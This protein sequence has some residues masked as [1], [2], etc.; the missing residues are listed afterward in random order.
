MKKILAV[1]ILAAALSLGL[2]S[3][4]A[5]RH[6]LAPVAGVA[7]FGDSMTENAT[8]YLR[9]HRPK[10]Y[11]DGVW[12]RPVTDL[13]GRVRYYLRTHALPPRVAIIALGTNERA[14]WSRWQYRRVNHLFPKRTRV[15]YVNTYRPGRAS[16]GARYS[17]WMA[18]IERIRKRTTIAD[19]R[20][21]AI[22]DTD[23][24]IRW[25]HLHQTD[26]KGIAVWSGLVMRAVK[27]ANHEGRYYDARERRH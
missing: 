25:D 5:A 12:G 14:G 7:M 8:P 1:C 22:A 6:R 21:A 17:R 19:W 2:M 20:S 13:P 27:A 24:L 3:P 16:D 18:D 9:A 11:I 26:P 15:V 10:W 23:G 4:A